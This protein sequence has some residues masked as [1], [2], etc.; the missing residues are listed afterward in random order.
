MNVSDVEGTVPEDHNDRNADGA[1]VVY[2]RWRQGLLPSA[3]PPA[4]GDARITEEEARRGEPATCSR[5]ALRTY[6]TVELITVTLS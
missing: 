4:T 6:S 5:R 2:L 1:S 3:A